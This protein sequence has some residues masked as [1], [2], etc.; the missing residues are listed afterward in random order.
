MSCIKGSKLTDDHKQAISRGHIR[1]IANG[2]KPSTDHLK[3]YQGWKHVTKAQRT[4]AIE[5]T[6]IIQ[7]GRPQPMDK[8]TGAHTDNK[9]AKQWWF[10]NKA[11]GATLKGKNLNQLIR[12]NISLFSEQDTKFKG[13][14]CTAVV[15]L[16]NLGRTRSDTGRIREM[17]K[18]WVIGY[19][20][21]SG[22]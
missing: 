22:K 11:L 13:S 18:G 5:K 1:V 9:A 8:V 19:G 16:R 15:C 7:T 21:G 4:I 14:Q 6:R 17:W 10:I 12:D 2:Y 20:I 3:K